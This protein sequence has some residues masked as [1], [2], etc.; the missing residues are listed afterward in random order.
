VP[1]TLRDALSPTG[2]EVEALGV[3]KGRNDGCPCFVV[4]AAFSLNDVSVRREFWSLGVPAEELVVRLGREEGLEAA[5]GSGVRT[6]GAG[7]AA[8]YSARG[9]KAAA[10][11]A[12]RTPISATG[13]T[14][15]ATRTTGR[16]RNARRG[17]CC[18]ARRGRG[19]AKVLL[20]RVARPKRYLGS[21]V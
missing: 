1:V 6:T 17:R 16:G 11:P 18:S 8:V 13:A 5:A 14:T 10:T 19:P 9:Q 15:R 2:F 4:G 20:P 3:L 21:G 7:T 12:P